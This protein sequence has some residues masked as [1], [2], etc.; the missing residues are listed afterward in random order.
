MNKGAGLLTAIGSWL[1]ALI[2]LERFAVP[3]LQRLWYLAQHGGNTGHGYYT[4]S[5]WRGDFW[6]WFTGN[7]VCVVG[8]AVIVMLLTGKFFDASLRELK[9]DKLPEE[10]EL[11]WQLWGGGGQ[12]QFGV[13]ELLALAFA[14]A[15]VMGA[16]TT[17]LKVVEWF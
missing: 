14:V 16:C 5:E 11:T 7:A 12:F 15:L 8:G 3:G 1:A 10:E 9:Y 2:V 17:P 4:S 13:A 6:W